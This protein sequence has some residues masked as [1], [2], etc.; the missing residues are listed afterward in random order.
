MASLANTS[1]A[2]KLEPM[3]PTET[4][5]VRNRSKRSTTFDMSAVQQH[6]ILETM[7]LNFKK[8]S[9]MMLSNAMLGEL[10]QLITVAKEVSDKQMKLH[11]HNQISTFQ[12]NHGNHI[13]Q[14]S[15]HNTLYTFGTLSMPLLEPSE[16][17][18]N[19]K[20]SVR[21]DLRASILYE[22]GENL[23]LLLEPAHH[24]INA[25]NENL[26]NLRDWDFDLFG[27]HE[28]LNSNTVLTMQC[29]G[30]TCMSRFRLFDILPLDK[31]A[32]RSYLG[33]IANDYK[34][35]P[36]HNALHGV[37]VM[38]SMYSILSNCIEMSSKLSNHYIFAILIAAAVHD[39][40]HPA[41]NNQFLV[42][43]QHRLSVV[44]H[45]QSVLE[46]YHIARSMELM[47]TE[48]FSLL[49]G[50]SKEDTADIRHIMI[51]SI[52]HTDMAKHAGIVRN[53]T[54]D[55]DVENSSLDASL[56]KNH[57]R[58]LSLLLHAA[59]VGNPAKPWK[60]YRKWTDKIMEEFRDQY[61]HE[62]R[63]GIGHGFFDPEKPVPEFQ[64]GFIQFVV[65]P[66]FTQINKIN[67]LDM[68]KALYYL[69]RNLQTWKMQIV[70]R[71]LNDDSN[72]V[73]EKATDIKLKPRS[74]SS[75]V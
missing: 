26:K 15:I 30:M 59:D 29:I 64:I 41:R 36:Y 21:Q 44:Y 47:E 62:E 7:K 67:G 54:L 20:R 46:N 57:S 28:A 40:G 56:S 31:Q 24:D 14:E 58:C 49:S 2:D 65:S 9:P 3:Q 53:L 61:E 27:M 32:L 60:V 39:V 6:N 45:D 50:F 52:L 70:H 12:K 35:V 22:E 18:R 33:N 17:G 68:E 42:L 16:V 71:E 10:L 19:K 23:N 43:T 8:G 48:S 55:L 25:L 72:S 34:Q 74:A 5:R 1:V 37:D 38:Q 69:R 13:S 11:L 51:N 73:H 75:T 63:L 66:L 4:Q